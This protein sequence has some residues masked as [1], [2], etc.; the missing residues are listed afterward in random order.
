MGS[1]IRGFSLI[2]LMVVIAI[3]GVLSIAAV[4]A[5]S[6]YI[7]KVQVQNTYNIVMNQLKILVEEYNRTG[8]FPT[9]FEFAG[10]TIGSG[11]WTSFSEPYPY[12]LIEMGGHFLANGAFIQA[13]M[14]G[15]GNSQPANA[16]TIGVYDNGTGMQFACGLVNNDPEY[17][18]P[19]ELMP[20]FCN[21][22]SVYN[23]IQTGQCS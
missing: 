2:E 14:S 8:S 20:D 12:G 18:V 13:N 17:E 11:Y 6:N 9:T 5:Y 7:K 21:C 3:V 23:F 19:Y 15:L 16:V 4:P 10:Q 22:V 1:V